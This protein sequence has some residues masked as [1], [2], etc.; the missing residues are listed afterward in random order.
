MFSG[1]PSV[2]A[3]YRETSWNQLWWPADTNGNGAPDVVRVSIA[4]SGN[5]CDTTTWRSR[6]DQAAT[7]A[8]Y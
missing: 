7:A 1:N 2:D 8:G 4:D 5:D 3:L 6:A